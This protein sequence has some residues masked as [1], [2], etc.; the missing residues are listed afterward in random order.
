MMDWNH[1]GKHD[2]QDHAFYNNVISDNDKKSSSQ[3]GESNGSKNQHSSTG[4]FGGGWMVW[5]FVLWII[6][7]F[8]K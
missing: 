4:S 2:W 1:D 3:S 7:L 6:S 5:L 8:L